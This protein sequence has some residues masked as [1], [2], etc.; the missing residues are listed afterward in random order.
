MRGQSTLEYTMFIV[1]A[2][3][4]LLGMGVY[5]RR[6][7]QANVKTVETQINREAVREP[8]IPE[9]PVGGGGGG[10]RPPPHDDFPDF[11]NLPTD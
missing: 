5:V 3:A 6:A 9:E 10:R 7:I 1:A 2:S 4:A 11:P 8:H